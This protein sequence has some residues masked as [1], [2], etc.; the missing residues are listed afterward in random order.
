MS[1]SARWFSFSEMFVTHGSGWGES[2]YAI[3]LLECRTKEE[4]VQVGNRGSVIFS[5]KFFFLFAHRLMQSSG[6]YIHRRDSLRVL[7]WF[8]GWEVA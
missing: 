5:M 6:G 2:T 3:L 7:A 4:E 8:R 1:V